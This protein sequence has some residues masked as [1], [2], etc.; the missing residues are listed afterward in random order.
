[1]YDLRGNRKTLSDTQEASATKESSYSYD[2]DDRLTS[3][4]IDGTK[5]SID[6]LPN[7]L[8]FQKTTGTIS[9]QYGYDAQNNVTS[10]KV[11]SGAQS[12]YIY[13]DRILLKKDQTANKD[14]YY[15]SNGHGDIVQMVDTTGAIVNSYGYDEWGNLTQ[16]KETVANNFKYA[17]EAYDSETGLYYLKARYYD[18][19]Q[20]RFLKEDSYEGQITNPLTLNSYTYVE[21]NPVNYVDP[22]GYNPEEP[23]QETDAVQG[24]RGSSIPKG[25]SG[26]GGKSSTNSS[27]GSKTEKPKPAPVKPLPKSSATDVDLLK[28]EQAA[29]NAAKAAEK[30]LFTSAMNAFK[31]VDFT[32]FTIKN[33]H[34]DLPENA[35]KNWSKFNVDTPEE[36]NKLVDSIIKKAKADNSLIKKVEDNDKVGSDGASSYKIWIDAQKTVGVNGETAIRVIYDGSSNPWNVFPDKIPLK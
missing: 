18:P 8:R 6:Y 34:L 33:K 28:Q 14:Y 15:L 2:P 16:N 5:T 23:S 17:G 21:N 25:S 29:Q 36:A 12:T 20:G 1:T 26:S 32:K 9:T 22:T 7:G 27:N 3:A 30:R 19:S 11:S 24:F 35:N 13:G 31:K 10:E 4:T